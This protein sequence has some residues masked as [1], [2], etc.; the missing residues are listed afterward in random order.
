MA[1]ITSIHQTRQLTSYLLTG[2]LRQ[3][4]RSALAGTLIDTITVTIY[5]RDSNEIVNDRDHVELFANTGDI[6]VSST[7]ALSWWMDPE[8]QEV[9]HTA[10]GVE[11]HILVLDFLLLDGRRFNYEAQLD[12]EVIELL[13]PEA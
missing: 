9:L 6:V 1:D 4:N 11:V 2:T 13:V 5:D 3:E 8:D 10:R 12:V 7:G